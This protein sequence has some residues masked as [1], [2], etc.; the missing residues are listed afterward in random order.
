MKEIAKMLIVLT[1]ICGICGLLLATV[2]D[3]TKLRIEEQE[4]LN[5]KG[6]AV[7][8]VLA[9]SSNDLI[10]DRKKVKIK[11]KEMFVFVGKK[12][13]QVWAIAYEV[14]GKGYGGDIKL[15][16]GFDVANKKLTGIGVTLHKETPGLGARIT[17]DI[18]SSGF[19]GKE[20]GST[21]KTKGDGGGI[22]AI[23]GA[24]ISSRGVCSAV[25]Q[26]V[27]IYNEIKSQ[28]VK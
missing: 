9:G 7:K 10:K 2:K 3:K 8:N 11:D 19:K 5:V 12:N 1:L 20:M 4:L 23:T 22:D 27:E 14:T 13:G 25:N 18:F 26:G 6:P 24:T 15:I 17:E 16:V 28:V 21:F